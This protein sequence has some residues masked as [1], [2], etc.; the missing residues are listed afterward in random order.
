LAEL[1]LDSLTAVE[2]G[3]ELQRLVPGTK[4]PGEFLVQPDITLATLFDVLRLS[5]S[6]P[7][8]VNSVVASPSMSPPA[9]STDATSSTSRVSTLVSDVSDGATTVLN[10]IGTNPELIQDKPG[11]LPVLLIHD[12]G[13]TALAYRLLGNIGRTVLGVHSPGL[14]EKKGIISIRHAADQYAKMARQWL[15]QHSPQRPRLLV[16]GWSLGGTIAIALAAAHPDLVV[17]VILLDPPPPGTAA[18]KPDEADRLIPTGNTNSSSGFSMLVKAQLKLNAQSLS[19]DAD[20][21]GGQAKLIANLKAPV[22]LIGAIEP[23]SHQ[24]GSGTDLTL[25]GS[26]S[27]WMLSHK[28]AKMSEAAWSDI[29]GGLLVGTERTAG[30]HFTMFTHAHAAST[31]RAVQH[32]VDTL[33][34]RLA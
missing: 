28:R 25:P 5:P 4:I 10:H 9:D 24:E 34:A 11:T 29:L 1:G 19:V 6:A 13:G 3:V 14:H 30:N 27:E 17:G 21:Q 23:L 15:N 33:E 18:M 2:I 20:R 22:Y 12:G 16:G 32:A 7:V 26:C 8:I 31:T